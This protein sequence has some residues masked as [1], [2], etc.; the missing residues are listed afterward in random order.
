MKKIYK[1]TE[2]WEPVRM[3]TK[4]YSYTRS[5][6]SITNCTPTPVSLH[7][8]IHRDWERGEFQCNATPTGGNDSVVEGNYKCSK[9]FFT[10]K[11]VLICS[12]TTKALL[13]M[14]QVRYLAY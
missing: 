14:G 8:S 11:H 3:Y 5:E 1:M 4:L 13:S 2:D 12:P 10:E 7:D 9:H 6:Y